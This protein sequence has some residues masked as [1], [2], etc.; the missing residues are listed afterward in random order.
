MSEFLL[1]K[2]CQVHGMK[3]LSSLFNTDRID[4]LYQEPHVE[5]RN[6]FLHYGNMTDSTNITRLIK[7]IQ[8]DEIYNLAAMSHIAVSFKTPKYT[9]NHLVLGALRISD[10]VRLLGLEKKTRIYHASTSELYGKVQE[11]PQSEK[12]PFLPMFSLCRR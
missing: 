8:P 2:G 1:R 7:E 4:H 12:T 10:A 9:D 6:L 11:V 5:H 3:R